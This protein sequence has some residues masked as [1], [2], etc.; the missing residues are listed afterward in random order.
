MSCC[1][2][3]DARFRKLSSGATPELPPHAGFDT[4][5]AGES[6]GELASGTVLSVVV[7]CS[8]LGR[9]R[10]ENGPLINKG[11]IAVFTSYIPTTLTTQVHYLLHPNL[12]SKIEFPPPG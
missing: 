2:S 5:K 9:G 6:E 3:R 12:S 1:T 4:V 8:G 10:W 11:T 7:R